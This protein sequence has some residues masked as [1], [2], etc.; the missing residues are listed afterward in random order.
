MWKATPEVLDSSLPCIQPQYIVLSKITCSISQFATFSNHWLGFYLYS[1]PWSL[2]VFHIFMDVQCRNNIVPMRI[3]RIY[4]TYSPLLRTWLSIFMYLQLS[5]IQGYSI[6]PWMLVWLIWGLV[7]SE[8]KGRICVDLQCR[9]IFE[10]T[11]H[12]EHQYVFILAF[13]HIFH[14]SWIILYTFWR[15]CV[16]H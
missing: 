11:N 4:N 10:S 2:Q 8:L 14:Y 7:W 15:A 5:L 12:L 3:P 9:K 6:R 16:Q 1:I 13:I